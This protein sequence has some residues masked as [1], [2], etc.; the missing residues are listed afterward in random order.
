MS[1]DPLVVDLHMMGTYYYVLGVHL[2][3]L[4]QTGIVKTP[5]T[6]QL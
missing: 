2:I 4:S 6:T 3:K 1:A 5:T